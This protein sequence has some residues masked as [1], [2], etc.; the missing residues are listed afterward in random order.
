MSRSLRSVL[1]LLVVALCAGAATPVV[2]AADDPQA[3]QS[4]RPERGDK[5]PRGGHGPGGGREREDPRCRSVERRLDGAQEGV[6][7]AQITLRQANRKVAAKQRAVRRASGRRAKAR[8]R[9]QL[10]SAKRAQR[11][12]KAEV[13]SAKEVVERYKTQA[14][15]LDCST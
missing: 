11:R 3:G 7:Q 6:G 12:A 2:V 15:T 13:R 5:G 8:A 9:R 1:A 10:R 4:A 14:R